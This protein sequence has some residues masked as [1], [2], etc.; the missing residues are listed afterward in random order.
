MTTANE[1]LAR[2]IS[3]AADGKDTPQPGHD[4]WRGIEHSISRSGQRRGRW[5][6]WA[7]ASAACAVLAVGLVTFNSMQSSPGSATP[8]SELLLTVLNQQHE[9][10]RQMLLSHYQTVGWDGKSGYVQQELEQIRASIHEVSEQLI[11]E[12]NNR[13]LWQLLQWL[14]SKELELLESQFKVNEQLQQV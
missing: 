10:Q 9:Q 3:E 4:L 2:L 13:Q 12:P 11:E 8:Q 5:L 7:W 6:N 1:K 14:Y